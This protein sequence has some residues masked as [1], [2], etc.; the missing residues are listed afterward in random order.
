[1]TLNIESDESSSCVVQV[2]EVIFAS[3][4]RFEKQAA[5]RMSEAAI[6]RTKDWDSAKQRR[7]Y[8]ALVEAPE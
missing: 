6:E 8:A 4:V 3:K 7:E 2:D 5:F 1:M